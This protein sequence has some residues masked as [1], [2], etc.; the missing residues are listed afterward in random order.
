MKSKEPAIICAWCEKE[1]PEENSQ[2]LYNIGRVCEQ[3]IDE[4]YNN[5]S[6]YCSDFCAMGCGCDGSC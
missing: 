1:K 2:A 6:G 3:C 5:R 4:N